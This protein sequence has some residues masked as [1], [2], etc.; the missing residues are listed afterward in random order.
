MFDYLE[1]LAFSINV[2]TSS[3]S[4]PDLSA[5]STPEL[6]STAYGCTRQ[7]AAATLS[8]V[9]PPARKSIFWFFG[10]VGLDLTFDVENASRRT[11][12]LEEAELEF[13]T[14][15]GSLGRAVLRGS[16]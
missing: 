3:K 1:F 16:V 14:G 5:S 8:A 13:F 11:L 10:A 7:I 4:L 9:S 15:A 12:R 6:T 2:L